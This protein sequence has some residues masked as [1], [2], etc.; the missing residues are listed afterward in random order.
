[1]STL[2]ISFVAGLPF[3]CRE[4]LPSLS[5]HMTDNGKEIIPHLLLSSICRVVCEENSKT[6]WKERLFEYLESSFAKDE[7][8]ICEI[9]A[10]SFI[11]IIPFHEN[12]EHWSV[13]LLGK[14]MRSEYFRIYGK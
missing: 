5:E 6:K 4:L 13:S 8:E 7:S 2:T 11:E 3:I 14:S 12:K 9:I 10:V 1:M